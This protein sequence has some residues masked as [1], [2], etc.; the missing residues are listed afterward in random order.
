MNNVVKCPNCDEEASLIGTK[1]KCEN[2]KYY[3]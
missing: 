2:C 1:T 3:G